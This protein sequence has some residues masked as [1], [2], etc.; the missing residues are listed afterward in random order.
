MSVFTIK[1]NDV[2]RERAEFLKSV[3]DA[4]VNDRWNEFRLLA[5]HGKSRFGMMSVNHLHNELAAVAERSEPADAPPGA[6]RSSWDEQMTRYIG[7]DGWVRMALNDLTSAADRER[8]RRLAISRESSV[9]SLGSCFANNLARE[10]GAL[11]FSKVATLRVEE[12]VNSPGLIRR[13]LNPQLIPADAK[14]AWDERF[15]VRSD[16][17]L[18]SLVDARLLILTFGV[19]L[20]LR[21]TASGEMDLD[22]NGAMERLRSGE[23]TFV[24]PTVAEQAGHIVACIDAISQHAPALPV[25]VTLSPVP[26]SGYYG[27]LNV[28]TAN[29]L[30]K[31]NLRQAIAMAR[32]ARPF[33]YAPIYEMVS[34]IAP[35][36]MTTGVWGDGKTSRHPSP[37]LVKDICSAFVDMLG[38]ADATPT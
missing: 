6:E 36:V 15:E 33:I 9:M 11:G 10:L 16:L 34:S 35:G 2:S 12:A 17:L 14:Q 27:E 28:A 5:D 4:A 1:I 20:E 21:S 32:N 29:A 19:G 24:F 13:Y 31:S 7:Y 26:L 18:R 23:S 22:V 8:L 25:V 3:V 30:S 37:A 38:R